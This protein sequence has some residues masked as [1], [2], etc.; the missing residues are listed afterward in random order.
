[1]KKKQVKEYQYENNNRYIIT[2]DI[3]INSKKII[4][5]ILEKA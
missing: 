4:K 3:V 1:M 5:N 2:E